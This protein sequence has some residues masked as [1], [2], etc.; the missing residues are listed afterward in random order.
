M[1]KIKQLL[2][3]VYSSRLLQPFVNSLYLLSDWRLR[4]MGWVSNF[5]K[6][7]AKPD[8]PL[9][10]AVEVTNICNA[11]CTF[12]G[13]QY[14]ERPKT[15]MPANLFKSIIDEYSALGGGDLR[16]TPVV[17]DSLVDKGFVEKVRYARSKP[18]IEKITIVTNAIL[19]TREKFEALVEAGLNDFSISISGLDAAEYERVYR[20][21]QFAEIFKNLL[22]ISGS[23]YFQRVKMFVSLRTDRIF[24]QF[25]K[26]YKELRRRGFI[27]QRI[28]LY[29]NWGGRIKSADLTGF[30]FVKP[31][32]T[33]KN[34]PCSV[35]YDGPTVFAGGQMT[36]CSCRD[37]NANS[38]L[39]LGR[40]QEVGLQAP[41]R[42]GQMEKLR[43]QFKEGN[44]PGICRDCRHYRPA[45]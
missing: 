31:N 35:L 41:W 23:A 40:F 33:R 43:K 29:D 19:L 12:C 37:L 4:R 17:G 27:M 26:N 14:Q 18:N 45:Y 3:K 28:G 38:E 11:D 5:N 36:A 2:E 22:E 21:D 32:R 34:I 8:R 44:L 1:K 39:S 6:A 7:M 42:D 30:M 20:K 10:L 25:A 13:Y 16:L 9:S 24:P 15:V